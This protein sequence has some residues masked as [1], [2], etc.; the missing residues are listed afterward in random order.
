[1]SPVLPRETA[2]SPAGVPLTKADPSAS[3]DLARHR[4]KGLVQPD[5]AEGAAAVSESLLLF[6]GETGDTTP[7]PTARRSSTIRIT[8]VVVGVLG[9]AAATTGAGMYYQ[10]RRQAATAAAAMASGQGTA[11]I[12]ARPEGAQVIVDG[13]ARG[14]TPI[15][16]TLSTG[17]HTLELQ[18]G[19]S[20]RS[21]PL[22]VAAGTTISQYVDLAP[23]APDT[24]GRLDVASDPPGAR[25]S[26]DGVAQGTTPLTI[27][28]IAAGE[29]RVAISSDGA[30]V[31][32]VVTVGAGATATV[33]AS[34]APLA[35]SAGWLTIAV[36]LDLQI[37]ENARLVGTTSA[38]RL[39]LPA[40]SHQLELVSTEFG[41]RTPL[42][43]QVLPGKTAAHTVSLPNGS[44]S[45]NA[46]PW[47]EVSL[48]GRALGTTPL[49]NVSVSIG[50]HEIIWKHPQFG[51]RRRV[52]SVQEQTPVR[53]GI[54]FTK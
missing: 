1:M 18:N 40:G 6:G 24:S 35:T 15:T 45:I 4:P 26:V 37:F 48:D 19:A 29:H 7:A 53:V 13:V 9:I 47:A 42:S 32:R 23:A 21:V 27:A 44:V 8:G 34:M 36:P 22:S 2:E 38:D 50:P 14:V 49:A 52:V 33:V 30:T 20:T 43:V 51:E 54:D 39:M 16:L 5:P 17:P 31:N 12:S 28:V 10:T 3:R 11:M 41:F 25:V 46:L